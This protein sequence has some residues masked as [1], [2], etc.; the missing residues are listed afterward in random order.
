MFIV[1]QNIIKQIV[2]RRLQ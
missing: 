2:V 1:T